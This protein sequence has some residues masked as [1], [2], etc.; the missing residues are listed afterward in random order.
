MVQ[1]F[2]K[3]YL[4]SPLVISTITPTGQ[5]MARK[6]FGD[7]GE[8]VY[9]PFDFPFAVKLALRNI[10][11]WLFVHTETEIWPN[12]LFALGKK[13]I[14]SVIVNGRI[15]IKSSR[16]YGWFRFF[17]RRVLANISVFGMQTRE[18]CLRIIRIGADPRRV[19]ISGNMKFDVPLPEVSN[20]Y[21]G[22]V[23][24]KMG[25][26]ANDLIFVVGS[27][28]EGEEEILL[29]VYQRLKGDLN[30]LKMLMAPRHPERCEDVIRLSDKLQIPIEKRTERQK[31]G[32]EIQADILLL[33]TIGELAQ[34]YCMGD[35]IFV[36]GSLVPIGG[37]NL[38]EPIMYRKP[39]LF[40]PYMQNTADIAN[41]LKD[42]GGG[43]E[44]Q[45]ED[46]C[47]Q[48]AKQLLGDQH[49]REQA[50]RAAFG[51]LEDNR[52]AT[53]KNIAVLEPMLEYE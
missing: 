47:Y 40:G 5:D 9:F 20:D 17:F 42:L 12:F 6:K 21:A 28:H 16:N 11:P 30:R 22:A 18:D 43:I 14:P 33:D 44:V 32:G 25:F 50:G 31:Q 23:R 24:K 45:D 53:E 2:R 39:V 35:V 1:A 19:H 34:A 37:H 48:A 38:L 36:G 41:L 15:S 46:S 13:D 4:K 7:A 51:I 29:Q 52:G 27:T 10:K 49:L 3:K 26:A 8:I